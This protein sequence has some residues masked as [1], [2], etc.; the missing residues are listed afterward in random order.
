MSQKTAQIIFVILNILSVF[1]VAYAVYD[2]TSI[3]TA[4]EKKEEL[5]PFDSGTYY[6][7][8]MSV[9]WVLSIIQ[10]LGLKNKYSRLLR[11]ANQTLVIWFVFMLLLA[12][13]IPNFL[14]NKL[15]EAGYSKCDDPREISR[16]AKGESSYYLKRGC[17]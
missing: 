17:E 4:I 16:V 15:E 2:F 14:S 3:I 5:I 7:L 8:L 12:N 13:L 11:L 1:A 6:L 10:Y 9:T